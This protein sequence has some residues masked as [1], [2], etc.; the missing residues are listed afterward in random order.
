MKD[1]SITLEFTAEEH[2]LFNDVINHA[3]DAMYFSMGPISFK[4]VSTTC[5]F[6]QRLLMLEK[7]KTRSYELWV[8]RFENTDDEIDSE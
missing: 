3:I 6:Q 7:I 8:E 2:D 1:H 4:D 5:E